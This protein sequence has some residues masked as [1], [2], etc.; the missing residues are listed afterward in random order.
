MRIRLDEPEGVDPRWRLCRAAAS[1]CAP[2]LLAP[3]LAVSMAASLAAPVAGCGG[4]AEE[5]RAASIL[6]DSLVAREDRLVLFVGACPYSVIAAQSVVDGD[7]G[8]RVLL[9][10]TLD[11]PEELRASVCEVTVPAVRAEQGASLEG[12]TDAEVCEIVTKGATAYHAAHFKGAYPVYASAGA[13]LAWEQEVP[14]MT[15][16]GLKRAHSRIL[17]ASAPS[18]KI[19]FAP[20]DGS[21][22][23]EQS[24]GY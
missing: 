6:F 16:L 12:K 23:I 20:D 24:L 18:A 13:P 8:D 5:D 9:T 21:S 4:A 3:L 17:D 15:S 11:A 7:L 19:D 2:A 22:T 10:A 14:T 1:S